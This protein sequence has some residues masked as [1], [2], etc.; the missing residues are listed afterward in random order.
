MVLAVQDLQGL[1]NV[2]I[3]RD[4]IHII[5]QESIELC[6]IPKLENGLLEMVKMVV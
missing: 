4:N 3:V 1:F 2:L 6:A 5:S